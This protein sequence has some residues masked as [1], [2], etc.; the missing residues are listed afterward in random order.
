MGVFDMH[1]S[2]P[3]PC[4]NDG[5]TY[6]N[7][8]FRNIFIGFACLITTGVSEIIKQRLRLIFLQIY[9]LYQKNNSPFIKNSIPKSGDGSP[10]LLSP[11]VQTEPGEVT[12]NYCSLLCGT[13]Y[14]LKTKHS[15]NITVP[16]PNSMY[17]GLLP[18]ANG[19]LPETLAI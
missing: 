16:A 17:H 9:S 12:R 4:K 8:Y 15:N 7:N 14:F 6:N 1:L 2:F 18:V 11:A 3:F 10:K 19:D 13:I 5:V